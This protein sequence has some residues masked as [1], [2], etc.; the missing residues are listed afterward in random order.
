[1]TY[2]NPDFQLATMATSAEVQ[3]TTTTKNIQAWIKLK[4]LLTK[5][6]ELPDMINDLN[7]AKTNFTSNQIDDVEFEYEVVKVAHAWATLSK[8]KFAAND[9]DFFV[10]LQS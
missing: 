5:S 2:S 10:G 7:L 8:Q 4:N 6:G 9:W 3:E 1:M